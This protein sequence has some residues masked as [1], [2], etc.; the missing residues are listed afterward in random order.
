[1]RHVPALVVPAL[2]VVTATGLAAS[3]ATPSTASAASLPA[4]RPQA[5]EVLAVP[6]SGTF[7]VHGRGWGHGIGMSQE[8]AIG[9]ARAGVG[10]RAILQHYYPGTRLASTAAQRLKVRL[11]SVRSTSVVVRASTDLRVRAGDTTARLP[12]TVRRWRVTPAAGLQ[13]RAGGRWVAAQTVGVTMPRRFPMTLA[14]RGRVRVVTTAGTTR[15]YDGTLS[16]RRVGSRL[17][18]R[19]IVP[20]NRYV[21][22]VVAREISAGAP[23]HALRAQ[24]VAARSYA[25]QAA[26]PGARRVLC[27][28]TACQVYGGA[29]ERGRDGRRTTYA[30]PAVRAASEASPAHGG[31]A[32][33][34][35]TWKG[36][37]ISAMFSA[38]NG[39][40]TVSADEKYGQ[41]RGTHPYLPAKADP[42]DRLTGSRSHAWTARL[43]VSALV[44]R[45]APAA[46]AR[47][48]RVQVLGRD[49]RGAFGGRPR[50]VLLEWTVAGRYRTT[51]VS[52]SALAAAYAWPAHAHGLRSPWWRL[53]SGR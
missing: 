22:A 20:V 48:V 38:A 19:N 34:V 53:Q 37:V 27:D 42:Y 47:L 21:S 3:L 16:L 9:A 17:R 33:Q 18:T 29:W 40:W 7:S 44:R 12:T 24:A 50:S 36:S 52:A 15:A 49:G 4:P 23:A 1:M 32:G 25:L 2:V 51:T 26:G 6:S 5:S 10:Y 35:L 41:P 14:A 39:G 28:T 31:T 8:G 43:P 13:A 11:S 45:F 30:T 46:K